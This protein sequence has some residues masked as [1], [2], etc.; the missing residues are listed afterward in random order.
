MLIRIKDNW[1]GDIYSTPIDLQ[2]LNK[3][4]L[5]QN[6]LKDYEIDK[7]IFDDFSKK[8]MAQLLKKDVTGPEMNLLLKN[9]LKEAYGFK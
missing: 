5:P 4:Y 9:V 1:L 2:R 8:K 7:N 3:C 6:K